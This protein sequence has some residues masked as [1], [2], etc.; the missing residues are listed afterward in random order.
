MR[1]SWFESIDSFMG[2]RASTG[3]CLPVFQKLKVDFGPGY[4]VN[5]TRRGP[6]LLLLLAGDAKSTQQKDIAK[7]I[8]LANNFQE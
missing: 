2:I 1:G 7:A 8:E 6:Q 3:I 4:R 5:Y